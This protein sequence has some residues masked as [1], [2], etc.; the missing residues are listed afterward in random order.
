MKTSY[1]T[2]ISMTEE[3][4]TQEQPEDEALTG[5]HHPP[6]QRQA[7]FKTYTMFCEWLSWAQPLAVNMQ[8]GRVEGLCEEVLVVNYISRNQ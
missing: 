2:G 3:L 1:F 4:N 8:K 7:L 5:E 6:K